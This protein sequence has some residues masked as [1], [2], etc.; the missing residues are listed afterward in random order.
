MTRELHVIEQCLYG[1]T[2]DHRHCR[3]VVT[4]DGAVVSVCRRCSNLLDLLP[5]E[6]FDAHVKSVSEGLEVVVGDGASAGEE[7]RED[8]GVDA[9]RARQVTDSPALFDHELP[10]RGVGG[11]GSSHVDTVPEVL[12]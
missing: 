6:V 12:E 2:G 10:E 4:D 5:E 1:A 9:A 11:E 3:A 7:V 8:A